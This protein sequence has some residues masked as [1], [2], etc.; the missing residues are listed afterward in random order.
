VVDGCDAPVELTVMSEQPIA[1]DRAG[2]GEQGLLVYTVSFGCFDENVE[3]RHALAD[4]LGC[5]GRRPAP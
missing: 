1:D 5:P 4:M 2:C 3:L